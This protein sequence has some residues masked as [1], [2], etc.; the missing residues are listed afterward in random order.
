MNFI[1]EQQKNK[2]CNI[3]NTYIQRRD[4]QNF[5]DDTNKSKFISNKSLK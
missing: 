5:L 4:T 1:S 3:L 2:K